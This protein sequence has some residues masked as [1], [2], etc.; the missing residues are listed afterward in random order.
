M[1]VKNKIDKSFGPA[2]SF[3]GI[4]LFCVGIMV[5]FFDFTGLVLVIIGAFV[6]FTARF[7]KVDYDKRRMKSTTI[8]FGILKSGK[9]ISI[10]PSMKVGI[11]KSNRVWQTNSWS[12]RTTTVISHNYLVSLYSSTNQ[13]LMPIKKVDS[14]EKARKEQNIIGNN[15]GLSFL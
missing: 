6:G 2:G 14:I 7:T 13:Q 12:N 9:W 4:I 11:K 3:A 10:D 1:V 8:F 5:T 15:L